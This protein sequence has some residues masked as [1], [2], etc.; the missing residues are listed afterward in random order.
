MDL[1]GLI[2]N[3]LTGA[4]LSLGEYGRALEHNLRAHAAFERVGDAY[5]LFTLSARGWIEWLF[6]HTEAARRTL[7]DAIARALEHGHPS[8]ASFAYRYR[9]TLELG[10]GDSRAAVMDIEEGLRLCQ[11]KNLRLEAQLHGLDARRLWFDGRLSE[12]LEVAGTAFGQALGLGVAPLAVELRLTLA[13]FLID[14]GAFPEARTELESARRIGTELDDDGVLRP[15]WAT[16]DTFAARIELALGQP[17][18]ALER[19]RATPCLQNT[20]FADRTAHAIE[21][22]RTMVCTKDAPGALE[23][24]RALKPTPPLAPRA[25]GAKLEAHLALGE[26]PDQ[27]LGD[28]LATLELERAA[29]TDRL[30]LMA[31]LIHALEHSGHDAS[32]V[33][34]L[35]RTTLASL[36]G[37]LERHPELHASLLERFRDALDG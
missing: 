12:A 30:E 11:G 2:E 14:L 32:A 35:G 15:Y 22:A 5:S 4:Y 28:A 8:A 33:I 13:G 34:A 10:Q 17:G 23:R 18:R 21:L 26:I 20:P 1:L 7:G 16:L 6:G 25:L 31:S 37:S 29:P 24:L 3:G 27:V 36:A 9:A 19:L